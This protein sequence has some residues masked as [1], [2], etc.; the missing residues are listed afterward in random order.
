M[1]L[2]PHYIAI[3]GPLRVGK[4]K[5]ATELATHL[6]GRDVLDPDANPHL[7]GFYRGRQGSAFRSQMHSLIARYHKLLNAR[8]TRSHVPVVADFLLEKDKL[9]AYLTLE[10]E[11]LE[12][13]DRYY[14]FFREQL[15]MPD[16]AVYLKASPEALKTRLT[17]DRT[18]SEATMSDAFL[19]G[20]V[21]AFDHFF[22]RF[23]AADVLI[24][25]TAETNIV[26]NPED[27]RSLIE[28][29]GKPVTGTQYFLPLGS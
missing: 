4:T 24:V 10:D 20:M 23:K 16:L 26:E 15:P 14:E 25:D 1:K 7:R 22:S 27:L 3:D 9:F 17:G 5:L 8:I 28:E 18:S 19:E 21:Q 12:I 2:A 6:R 13:Y 29:L 11:E